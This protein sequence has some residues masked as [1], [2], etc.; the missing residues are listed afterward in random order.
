MRQL[1]TMT[2]FSDTKFPGCSLFFVEAHMSCE[3]LTS[4][5]ANGELA[6]LLAHKLMATHDYFLQISVDLKN[7]IHILSF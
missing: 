3:E 5:G 2:S 6:K 7:F 4:F 1:L